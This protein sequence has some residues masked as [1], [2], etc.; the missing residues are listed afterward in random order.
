MVYFSILCQIN[1]RQE[2]ED[3]EEALL[4]EE[5]KMGGGEDAFGLKF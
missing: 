2:I 4:S 1:H 3:S 5:G